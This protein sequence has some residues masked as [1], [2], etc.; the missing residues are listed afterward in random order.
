M[1]KLIISVV[2]FSVVV[3]QGY[4]QTFSLEEIFERKISQLGGVVPNGYERTMENFYVSVTQTGGT[5][6]LTQNA[7]VIM[8]SE[9]FA[10]PPAVLID[11]VFDYFEGNGWVF[12]GKNNEIPIFRRNDVYAA[13]TFGD[14]LRIDF[15]RNINI[16]FNN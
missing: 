10:D 12:Q 14:M 13:I 3:L 6:V 8:S 2:L 4:A 1:K 16:L 5:S 7:R 15:S 9:F 11:L